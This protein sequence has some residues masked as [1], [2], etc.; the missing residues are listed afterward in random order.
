MLVWISVFALVLIRLHLS[1]FLDVHGKFLIQP[2]VLRCVGSDDQLDPL[3]NFMEV[4]KI[5]SIV[6]ITH[7]V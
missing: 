5:V 1:I 2:C 3:T 4:N 6:M 7:H